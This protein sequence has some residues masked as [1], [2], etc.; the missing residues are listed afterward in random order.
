METVAV[1]AVQAGHHGQAAA[2]GR[3]AVAELPDMPVVAALG[4]MIKIVFLMLKVVAAAAL[5]AAVLQV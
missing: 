3:E 2:V 1:Q 5:V 4:K